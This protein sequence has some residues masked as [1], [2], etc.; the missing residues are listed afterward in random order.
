MN[1]PATW[2]LT[3]L[4]VRTDVKSLERAVA[5]T[6]ALFDEP[7]YG[8]IGGLHFP[9]T[10]SRIKGGVQRVIGTGK[11]DS[12]DWSVDQLPGGASR[13]ALRA[14]DDADRRAEARV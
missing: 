12:C 3:G 5:R 6:E 8:V 4:Q 10:G 1:H 2:G 13:Q 11:H 14:P 9:V 7:L